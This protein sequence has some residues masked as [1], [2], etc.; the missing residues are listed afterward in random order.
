MKM[1]LLN[2][3][4]VLLILG[5][6]TSIQ[7]QENLNEIERNSI[8][9]DFGTWLFFIKGDISYQR[10]YKHK[11]LANGHVFYGYK[12][13]TG[14]SESFENGTYVHTSVNHVILAGKKNSHFEINTGLNAYLYDLERENFSNS[15]SEIFTIYSP[16]IDIGY[17][18]QNM[19]KGGFT[20]RTG[21]GWPTGL[22]AGVG[23][24]F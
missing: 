9:G 20:F 12:F 22:Y 11:D 3:A 19:G 2:F 18:F 4:L 7:A 14:I 17:R 5:S 8:T 15:G 13:S 23:W 24:S 6:T 16:N 10:I 1:K 21:I